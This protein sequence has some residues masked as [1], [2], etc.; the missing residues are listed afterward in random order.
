MVRLELGGVRSDAE[1]A[2]GLCV[3]LDLGMGGAC[4]GCGGWLSLPPSVPPYLLASRGGLW[5]TF[6]RSELLWAGPAPLP[7]RGEAHS[8]T[9]YPTSPRGAH[10]VGKPISYDRPEPL[11]A[12]RPQPGR[13]HGD[14]HTGTVTRGRSH[15]DGHAALVSAA[16]GSRP[17][18]RHGL[19]CLSAT[20]AARA[21]L[22]RH[23][24]AALRRRAGRLERWAAGLVW[25]AVSR[26]TLRV[27][28][29]Q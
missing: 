1:G 15:G 2:R 3:L 16:L 26:A 27:L 25:A 21:L 10:L 19:S 14:G 13:S 17:E 9:L 29:V 6:L 8:T 4:V 24:R 18:R 11:R 5:T 7:S 23:R 28:Y 12:H 22:L 20:Q